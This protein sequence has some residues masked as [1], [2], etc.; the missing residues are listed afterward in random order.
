MNILSIPAL[1]KRTYTSRL[2]A[3]IH[4]LP[5]VHFNAHDSQSNKPKQGKV[6]LTF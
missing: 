6:Y 3:D 2:Y 4:F 1:A 5:Y